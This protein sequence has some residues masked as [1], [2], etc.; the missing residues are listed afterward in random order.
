M[1][2]RQKADALRQCGHGTRTRAT[3]QAAPHWRP[4]GYTPSYAGVACTAVAWP[5]PSVIRMR[6][7]PVVAA[8][9]TSATLSAVSF[10]ERHAVA[11]SQGG[12][13]VGIRVATMNADGNL[14]LL[15]HPVARLLLDQQGKIRGAE[16]AIHRSLSGFTDFEGA[17]PGD[18]LQSNKKTPFVWADE[19][20]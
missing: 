14:Y 7:A 3:R 1:S 2:P 17:P 13:F 18:M 9:V 20:S 10:P 4:F 16:P 6:T 15:H 19:R 11:S 12:A 5:A 8:K